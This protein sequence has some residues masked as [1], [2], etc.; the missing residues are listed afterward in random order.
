MFLQIFRSDVSLRR[1]FHSYLK[2]STGFILLALLAGNMPLMDPTSVAN[3]S[4]PATSHN[5]SANFSVPGPK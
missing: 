2:A 1:I 5:G 4:V 3:I